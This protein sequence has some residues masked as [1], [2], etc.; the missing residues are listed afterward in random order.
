MA[1]SKK[2]MRIDLDSHEKRLKEL[3]ATAELKIKNAV[4]IFHYKKIIKEIKESLK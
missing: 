1:I 2:E 3:S 4:L